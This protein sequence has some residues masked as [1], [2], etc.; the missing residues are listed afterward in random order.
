ML[1]WSSVLCFVFSAYFKLLRLNTVSVLSA[2]LQHLN[3]PLSSDWPPHVPVN[4]FFPPL[5]TV[6]RGVVCVRVT[7]SVDCPDHDGGSSSSNSSRAGRRSPF[8]SSWF[9]PV[10]GGG[11]LGAGGGG[12]A[13]VHR[14]AGGAAAADRLRWVLVKFA[15]TDT[16]RAAAPVLRA[17]SPRALH[18]KTREEEA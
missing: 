5:T 4:K 18:N 6:G 11:L 9:L 7:S 15:D 12:S 10:C 16:N 2:P 13:A 17:G 3:A 1:D 8:F 14:S